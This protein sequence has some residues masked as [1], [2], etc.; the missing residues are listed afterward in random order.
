MRWKQFFTPVDSMDAVEAK[1]YIKEHP[2]GSFTLLDVRQPSEYEAG[3][4]SGS[5]L[6]PL[7]ELKD[8][9]AEIDSEQ[10]VIT[11]CAIGGRSR[12]AA[13]MMAGKN[14]SKVYNLS[15][16]F[17]AWQGNSAVGPEDQGLHLFS[18]KETPEEVLTVAY[19]LEK[20]L[21]E[22]YLLMVPHM[23][24]ET[25]K[26]LFEKLSEIEI[27]HQKR[28]FDEYI[29]MTGYEINRDDFDKKVE[30][31]GMEGGLTTDEY[32]KLYGSELSSA[33][34]VIGLAMSIE[35]QALDLYLRS[36]ENISDPDS[37]KILYQIALEEQAH[38][39]QL[40]ELMNQLKDF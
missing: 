2:Q 19:S 11:Y 31:Y 26:K 17:K 35:A 39:Q 40:G 15:G 28:V 27:N 12:V 6:V 32:I 13:Q 37:K 20:G 25:S 30:D 23:K 22:F 29:R 18:G 33:Q 38:L 36:A 10:P 5:K 4:I 9:L 14:F 34:D 24:D 21:R 8:R 16:G 1:K 3:H 7:P